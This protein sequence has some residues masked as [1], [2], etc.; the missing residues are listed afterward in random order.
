MVDPKVRDIILR[1]IEALNKK[2]IHVER[3]LLFGSY[4]S[5]NARAGSDLDV[6]I[7][8]PDFGKDRFE[9]GKM[10]FQVAWRIDPRIEPIP[11]SSKP[12]KTIPG[13]HLYMK[14]DRKELKLSYWVETVLPLTLKRPARRSLGIG[15]SAP[16][17]SNTFFNQPQQPK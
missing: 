17:T 10:L 3:A 14:L 4:A 2:G 11:I 16:P 1:F 6:A 5:G 8:S 7:V 15:R 13:Y 12:L 9:E